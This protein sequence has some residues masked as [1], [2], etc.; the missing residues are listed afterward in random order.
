MVGWRVSLLCPLKQLEGAVLG[1]GDVSRLGFRLGGLGFR[2]RIWGFVL[3][4][5]FGLQ[6]TYGHI[7]WTY[8]GYQNYRRVTKLVIRSC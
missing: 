1:F 5:G 3:K 4:V 8:V 6:E 2:C 7:D